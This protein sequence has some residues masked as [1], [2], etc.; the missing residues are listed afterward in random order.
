MKP[1][2]KLLINGIIFALLGRILGMTPAVYIGFALMWLGANAISL[3]R[4]RH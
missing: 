4:N 2:T 1:G 3:E